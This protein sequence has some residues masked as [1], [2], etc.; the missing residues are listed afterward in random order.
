MG[1]RAT[2][3]VGIILGMMLVFPLWLTPVSQPVTF[4]VIAV[5]N[6]IECAEISQRYSEYLEND[7]NTTNGDLVLYAMFN[8]TANYDNVAIEIGCSSATLYA[9][10]FCSSDGEILYIVPEPELYGQYSVE[11]DPEVRLIISVLN[12]IDS[13][14][15]VN[16]WVW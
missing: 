16:I 4:K 14:L 3:I 2:F 1:R 6:E 12:A 5:E 10:W 15:E 8:A 9:M 7:I 11:N 13:V